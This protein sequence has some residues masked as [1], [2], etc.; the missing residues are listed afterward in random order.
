MKRRISIAVLPVIA[1]VAA[2]PGDST[3]AAP[4]TGEKTSGEPWTG[5]PGITLPVSS[6]MTQQRYANWGLAGQPLRGRDE[7]EREAEAGEAEAEPAEEA[8][9]GGGKEEPVEEEAPPKS[10]PSAKSEALTRAAPVAPKSELS[11]DTSFLGAH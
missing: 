1:L 6:L 4:G 2:G 3:T 8:A 5:S 9:A 10:P 11:A 7:P